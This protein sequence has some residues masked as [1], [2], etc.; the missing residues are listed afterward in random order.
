MNILNEREQTHG[1]YGR[2]ARLSQNLKTLLR[3]EP[4]RLSYQQME[5]VEMICVKLARIVCGNPDE[6]DH[7]LDCS[8]YALLAHKQ[9][10]NKKRAGTGESIIEEPPDE[11]DCDSVRIAFPDVYGTRP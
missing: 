6:P 3:A 4:H 11:N 2:T 9:L 10:Q 1:D 7:W 8:G 5:A